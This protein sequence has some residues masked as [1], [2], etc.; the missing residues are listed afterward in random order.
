MSQNRCGFASSFFSLRLL[1]MHRWGANKKAALVD[2]FDT[3][4]GDVPALIIALRETL[5][6]GP[7]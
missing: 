5:G 4:V 3:V 1:F 6:D 2:H 7:N